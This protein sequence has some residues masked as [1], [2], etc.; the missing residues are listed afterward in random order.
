MKQSI[1]KLIQ[2]RIQTGNLERIYFSRDFEDLADNEQVR[3]ALSRLVRE[4]VLDRVSHGIYAI[5]RMDPV[6]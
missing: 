6:F 4:K 2:E 3:L 5:N 1:K